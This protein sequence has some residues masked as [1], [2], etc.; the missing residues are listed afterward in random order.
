MGNAD[1]SDPATSITNSNCSIGLGRPI[2]MK[3]Q[4]TTR[5]LMT[6]LKTAAQDSTAT[7]V[8]TT[9][10]RETIISTTIKATEAIIRALL[11]TNHVGTARHLDPR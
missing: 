2:G 4:M 3:P 1:P 6:I 8:K 9:F 11:T 5:L 10:H 7:T